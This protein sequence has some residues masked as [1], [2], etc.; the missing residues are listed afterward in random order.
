[1]EK[2]KSKVV[3]QVTKIITMAALLATG[4]VMFALKNWIAGSIII[5][6]AGMYIILGMLDSMQGN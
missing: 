6:S 4:G 2:S 3:I 1:M 5:I